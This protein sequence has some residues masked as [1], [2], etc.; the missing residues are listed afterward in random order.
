MAKK[1]KSIE[2]AFIDVPFKDIEGYEGRYAISK[3]G[4]VFSYLRNI[5]LHPEE[6]HN[7]YLRV[8]LIDAEGSVRHFR[9]HR[10]VAETFIPNP[11]E[12]TQV[13]HK[14]GNRKDNRVENLEWATARENVYDSIRRYNKLWEPK[15]M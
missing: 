9:V 7:G 3:D 6:V 8:N 13:N 14:N 1:Y 5:I 10:L 4:R 2:E 11:E 15:S 12:K